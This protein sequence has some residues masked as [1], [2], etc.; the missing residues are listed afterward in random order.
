LADRLDQLSFLTLS[1]VSYSKTCD[2]KDRAANS[3]LSSLEFAADVTA[4]S[5]NRY[6]RWDATDGLITGSSASNTD[7]VAADTPS[8]KML[9]DLKAYAKVQYLRGM[10]ASGNE[11]LY[12]VFMHPYGVAKLKQDSDFLA[13]LRSAGPRGSG[14][15]LFNGGMMTHDG[16]VIHEFRHVY[17]TTG[18]ADGSKWGG[19]AVDGQRVLLCGAQALGMADLGNPQWD[20][21]G[22]DYKNGQGIAIAKI[23]GLKKPVFRS[24][25]TG[26]DEDFGVI[27]VDTAI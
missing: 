12:H 1:G 3:Q 16:L 2:G 5:T 22:F 26:T 13:N 8:Y 18:A 9:V 27:C 7:L 25:V 23:L 15:P 10:R 24:H 17:N 21:E 4:P 20:E 19:G 11:E 14:N 6:C